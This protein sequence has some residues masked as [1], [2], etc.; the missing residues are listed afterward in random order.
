MPM[1]I[2]VFYH[3][4]LVNDWK[5][6]FEFHL[7]E[8]R[9]SGLYDA[10]KQVHLGVVYVD[11]QQLPILDSILDRQSKVTVCFKRALHA[12]PF[13]IWRDPE[14][15]L[16]DGRFGEA[17]SILRMV[18]FAQGRE[19][20]ET[21]LFVHSKGVTNPNVKNRRQLSYFVSRGF[22]PAHSNDMAN[23]FVLED[24]AVVVRNW[25]Q[26]CSEV[27]QTESFRYYT[28]NFFWVSGHLLRK[29]DF[30]E[31]IR[32]HR[33]LAP[34][35]QR[36]HR[37]GEHWNTTR[38]MFSLFP[39]KLHAFANRIELNAPPYTYIDVS[40]QRFNPDESIC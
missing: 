25:R 8:I 32:L 14:I 17:E 34:P 23:A 6:I 27:E 13:R 35:R 2:I 37:L 19:A 10:C 4:Y 5:R 15:R 26:Y 1:S 24:T 18:E 9:K 31:Y 39:V 33:E 12:H 7:K 28:W 3:L 20:K 40:M 21:Y 38:H 11:D 22:D 16:N 29:F 36:R 30:D